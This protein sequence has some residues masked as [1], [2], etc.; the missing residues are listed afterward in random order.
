MESLFS[1]FS[2]NLVIGEIVVGI[3]VL[4][5]VLCEWWYDSEL[6][7]YCNVYDDFLWGNNNGIVDVGDVGLFILCFCYV[8]Q[9]IEI[10]Q[11]KFDGIYYMD[12]GK[13]QFGVEGW[14]MEMNVCQIVGDNMMLGNWGI[15]NLGE[16]FDGLLE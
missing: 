10:M 13:F 16:F 1:G 9:V 12:N 11:F 4:F 6:F 8:F 2:D 7:S 14:V 15:V 5:V 3:G